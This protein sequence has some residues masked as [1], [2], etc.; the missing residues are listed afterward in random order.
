M[1]VLELFCGTKSFSNV[2][3]ERGHDVFTIDFNNK[4][5]PDLCIDI[6]VFNKTMLPKSFKP[7]V[8]WASP[9]CETFSLSGNSYYYGYPTNSRAYI[10]LA[11]TYKCLE[12][13]RDLKPKFWIIENPRAGLRTVWFMRLL[14][15]TT[16]SY[17]QYG[18]NKM[19]PTDLFNNFGYKAKCCKNGDKCHISAPRGS[20]NGTQGEKSKEIRGIIPRELCLEIIRYLEMLEK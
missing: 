13:I 6:L 5:N 8:I 4:F 7:D 10:G 16:A 9:P 14:E 2:C 3:K 11:L 12:I 17:C 20:K 15:K 18:D 19:K 1:K